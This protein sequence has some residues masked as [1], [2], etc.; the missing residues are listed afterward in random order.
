MKRMGFCRRLCIEVL[1][2]SPLAG[3]SQRVKGHVNASYAAQDGFLDDGPIAA[4]FR[5]ALE[6]SFGSRL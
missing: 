4:L 6:R 3:V 2:G 1:K 5:E